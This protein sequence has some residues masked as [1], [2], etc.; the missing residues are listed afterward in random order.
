MVVWKSMTS[1]EGLVAEFTGPGTLLLQTRNIET[2]RRRAGAP[3]A[4]RR[5]TDLG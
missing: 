2:P 1:G 3:H 4:H 5:L